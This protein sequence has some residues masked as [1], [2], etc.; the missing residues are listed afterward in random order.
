MAGLSPCFFFPRGDPGPEPTAT[1]FKTNEL[2]VRGIFGYFFLR[3]RLQ[4]RHLAQQRS[5][6]RELVEAHLCTYHFAH[7][8]YM[9]TICTNCRLELLQKACS[10]GRMCA[11][12]MNHVPR[13]NLFNLSYFHIHQQF[14][15]AAEPKQLLQTS[16]CR[17]SRPRLGKSER[18]CR[19]SYAPINLYAPKA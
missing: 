8:L 6:P 18:V 9:Q 12:K 15:C 19:G 7:R 1:C 14:Q 4:E 10:T 3:P 2:W 5:F 13:R 11:S 17:R 16:I